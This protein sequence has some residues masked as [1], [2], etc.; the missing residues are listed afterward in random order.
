[1]FPHLHV[2]EEIIKPFHFVDKLCK[3]LAETYPKKRT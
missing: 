1:M 2:T 3:M